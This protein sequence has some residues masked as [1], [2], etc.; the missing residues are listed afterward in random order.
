[1]AT[2]NVR[3][4][5]D[6]FIKLFND[7]FVHKP[8]GET[9]DVTVQL[10]DVSSDKIFNVYA[11]ESC[12]TFL[13]IMKVIFRDNDGVYLNLANIPGTKIQADLNFNGNIEVLADSE[14]KLADWANVIPSSIINITLSK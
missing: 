8:S 14:I 1:M 10:L 13:G 9:E 6:R 11:E 7:S 2:L 4:E 12:S 3:N 5:S